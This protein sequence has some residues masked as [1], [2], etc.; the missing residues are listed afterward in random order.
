MLIVTVGGFFLLLKYD[1]ETCEE[2]KMPFTEWIHD[3]NHQRIK[4]SVARILF[5]TGFSPP[6]KMIGSTNT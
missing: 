5:H 6:R 2:M 3:Y 4:K 1:D